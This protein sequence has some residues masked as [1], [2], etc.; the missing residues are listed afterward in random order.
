MK[1]R[2]LI[3][4]LF[5]DKESYIPTQAMEIASLLKNKGYE[6]LTISDKKNRILRLLHAIYFLVIYRNK[7]DVGMVQL[8]SGLSVY[9][10][11]VSVRLLK[12][13]N[14][15]IIVTIRGGGIPAKMKIDPG[16]YLKMLRSAHII[17]CPSNFM[18]NAM[19]EYGMDCELVEN[20]IDMNYYTYD[21][22]EK[23]QPVLFWMRAFSPIYNPQMAVRVIKELKDRYNY[24]NIKLYMAGP[25]LGLKSEVLGMI[26]K[27]GLRDNIELVGFV[28][29]RNKAYFAKVSDIYIC[30]NNID[31]APVSFLEMIA[32]GLPIVSTNVG[33]IPHIVTDNQ[34]A[35]L[36]NQNDHV[37]MAEKI[38]YLISTP[39]AGKTLSANGKNML[40]K[41]SAEE[42]FKKWDALLTERI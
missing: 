35:L 39:G 37:G 8:F 38:H 32:F 14:K 4:G 13:L 40:N 22:R 41:Y 30:T 34:T 3:I 33:G 42:V 29:M 23:L 16:I 26:K 31:N 11:Y 9:W 7:Y 6:V 12:T 2:I 28:N 10:G 19:K 1:K 27:M 24:S 20:V 21:P 15:K 36:V 5:L 25:D 17:T 18:I